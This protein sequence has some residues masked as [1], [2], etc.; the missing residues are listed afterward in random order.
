MDAVQGLIEDLKRSA[1]GDGLGAGAYG[2][3]KA[4]SGAA[5]P[6][7]TLA[8]ASGAGRYSRTCLYADETFELVLLHWAAT[9]TSSVHDHGGQQ[10]WFA[11]MQGALRV[12]NFRRTDAALT[13]GYAKAL[14][15]GEAELGVRDIDARFE[16]IDL[17]RVYN[18]QPEPALSLHVYANPIREFLE[19]DVA[20]ERCYSRLSSYDSRI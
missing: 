14:R 4:F 16:G 5:P 7:L 19:F 2:A 20:A 10:C 18:A 13:P 6:L 3:L 9:A 17:H 15:L 12:E 11:V 8:A 1:A